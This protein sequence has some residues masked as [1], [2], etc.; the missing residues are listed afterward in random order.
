MSN[1]HSSVLNLRLDLLSPPDN[2]RRAVALFLQQ[3]KG[4]EK[5]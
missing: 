4:K 5:H 1:P 3:K 2:H